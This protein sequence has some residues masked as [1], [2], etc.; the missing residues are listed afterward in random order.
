M[1]LRFS[2][3][4]LL[5]LT[6]VVAVNL[7]WF[8]YVGFQGGQ[9]YIAKAEARRWR[10]TADALENALILDGWKIEHKA[11]DLFH[12]RP[13]GSARLSRSGDHAFTLRY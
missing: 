13:A 2:V 1:K 11:S 10:A 4:D 5:W 9:L 3:R 8:L 12:V 7:G 6:L